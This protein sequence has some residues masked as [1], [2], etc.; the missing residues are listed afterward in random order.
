MFLCSF[1]LMFAVASAT[2]FH[3][4]CHLLLFGLLLFHIRNKC[5]RIFILVLENL[6]Y[7][8]Y[9]FIICLSVRFD[10]NAAPFVFWNIIGLLKSLLFIPAI[11]YPVGQL[12]VH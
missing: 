8:F 12:V 10:R 11:E 9:R 3:Y 7:S 6:K 5:K 4:L 2:A 1:L